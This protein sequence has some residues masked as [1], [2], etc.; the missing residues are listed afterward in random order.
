[1]NAVIQRIDVSL[2]AHVTTSPVVTAVHVHVDTSR[3]PVQRRARTWMSAVM[4]SC[5]SM[6]VSICL[7]DI[8]ASVPSALYST[9]TGTSAL[10]STS[11][12]VVVMSLRNL[13]QA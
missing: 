2:S 12:L 9:S 11:V 1:M 7:V 3:T 6:D 4:T 10:V 5:V 8:G 13:R